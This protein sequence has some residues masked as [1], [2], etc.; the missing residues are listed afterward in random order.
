MG[1]CSA[2][3][4]YEANGI[5]DVGDDGAG[6]I[7]ADCD[8]FQRAGRCEQSFVF[9]EGEH[10]GDGCEGEVMRGDAGPGMR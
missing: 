7:P 9:E 5:G 1:S 4:C 6:D 3:R 8:E 2:E 10:F